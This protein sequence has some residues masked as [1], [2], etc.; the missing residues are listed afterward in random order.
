MTE[1]N[2]KPRDAASAEES[3]PIDTGELSYYGSVGLVCALVTLWLVLRAPGHTALHR[4]FFFVLVFGVAAVG[5]YHLGIA[6]VELQP[7][8]HR[9]MP[10]GEVAAGLIVGLVLAAAFWVRAHKQLADV[11]PPDTR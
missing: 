1:Q 7:P 4:L 6:V 3:P 9:D 10:T 2:P 11:E 5:T 8:L